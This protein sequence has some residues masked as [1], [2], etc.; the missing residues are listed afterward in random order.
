MTAMRLGTRRA[1]IIDKMVPRAVEEWL[2]PDGSFIFPGGV[3]P[4]ERV[5]LDADA[6]P[7]E[8]REIQELT[9]SALRES[10]DAQLL[11]AIDLLS[12]D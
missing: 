7:L 11:R 1:G 12:Q 4:D 5:E 9:P 2:T 10:G 6:V 8:P 3:S